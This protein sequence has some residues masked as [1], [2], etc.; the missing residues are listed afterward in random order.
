[1]R[2][3]HRLPVSFQS[4]KLNK[5]Q[6]RRACNRTLRHA[7]HL[8]ARKSTEQSARAKTYYDT[9]REKGKSHAQALRCL[10][11]RWLKIISK[12]WQTRT[13]YDAELHMENQ[14]THGSWVLH[15]QP[16]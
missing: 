15:L 12:M 9:L 3:R 10:G 4:G 7:M 11:Q 14:L 16:A 2:G 13:R 5:A 6:I 8:F 1:M